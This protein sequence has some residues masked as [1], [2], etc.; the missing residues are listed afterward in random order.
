MAQQDLD[1]LIE[2]EQMRT[3]LMSLKQ[4]STQSDGVMVNGKI[5][6]WDD[7]FPLLNAFPDF[8]T[9]RLKKMSG[10]VSPLPHG[11]VIITPE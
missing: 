1:L 7:A 8:P 3:I 4:L 10:W 6:P 11:K 9:T 2:S 5:V